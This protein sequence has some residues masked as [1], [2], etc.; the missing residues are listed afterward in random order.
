MPR[1]IKIKYGD[2][3]TELYF[4]NK[5]VEDVEGFSVNCSVDDIVPAINVKYLIYDKRYKEKYI[6]EKY[7]NDIE[8]GILKG[9]HKDDK[10]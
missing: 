2:N 1:E 9:F 7:I 8:Q 4:D 10:E 5:L 6:N 3:G